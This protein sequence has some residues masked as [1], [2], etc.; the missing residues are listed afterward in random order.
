MSLAY[1]KW[2]VVA[3]DWD[4]VI[5]EFENMPYAD[6]FADAMDKLALRC[7]VRPVR[8]YKRELKEKLKNPGG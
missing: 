5:A 6:K 2:Q 7:Y 3:Y 8:D 1:I 4:E